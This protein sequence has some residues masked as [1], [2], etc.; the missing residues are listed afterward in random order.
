MAI[1]LRSAPSVPDV[2]HVIE[3]IDQTRRTAMADLARLQEWASRRNDRTPSTSRRAQAARRRLRACRSARRRPAQECARVRARPYRGAAASETLPLIVDFAR[4]AVFAVPVS[5][6]PRS[7]P[8]QPASLR[9]DFRYDLGMESTGHPPGL[10]RL[11]DFARAR[12][13]YVTGAEIRTKDEKPVL[14]VYLD[15]APPGAAAELA[16]VVSAYRAAEGIH[17][18]F[19]IMGVAASKRGLAGTA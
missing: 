2:R 1:R 8:W 11:F 16:Q 15:Q 9:P 6:C 18:E 19:L 7:V 13:A 3:E 10:I 12:S 4:F 5:A 14:V 17:G